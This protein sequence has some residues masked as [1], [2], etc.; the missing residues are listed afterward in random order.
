MSMLS[1][2]ATYHAELREQLSDI[3]RA[4]SVQRALLW[5][6][7]GLAVG[8]MFDLLL[9]LWAWARDA[10]SSLSLPG[11]VLVPL[12]TGLVLALLSLASRF[13]AHSLARRVDRAAGLQERSVTALELGR[14][15]DEHALAIAQMRDAVEHLR[16]LDL[17][18][19][20]PIQVPKPELMTTL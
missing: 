2:G 20:F 9:V 5:L 18:E 12:G 1:P 17:L 14:R 10:V 6:A 15:G 19:T 4:L 3:G 13:E 16:R 8:T 11:L 7:R